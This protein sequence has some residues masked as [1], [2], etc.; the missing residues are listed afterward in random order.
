M[1]R[2]LSLFG[3]DARIRRVR[4]ALSEGATAAEDRAQLLG[5]A[6]EDEKGHLKRLMVLLVALIGLTIVMASLLSVAVVV[7]FWDTPHRTTAAW[8][9]AAL[10][11]VL[12]VAA[13]V[14]LMSSLR[15]ASAAME[16]ARRELERDWVYLQTR[17]GGDDE[18]KP[19]EP[20]PATRQA[21]LDRIER[22]RQRLM[23]EERMEAAAEAAAAQEAAAYEPPTDKA[24]RLAR[25]HPIAT[26]AAAAVVMAVVGPRHLLKVTGWLVPI[27][28]KL[29]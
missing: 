6:W 27:L 15:G 25:E 5:M 8:L 24:M 2:L 20:R 4:A 1:K 12:W 7:H 3:I 10:W 23:L 26:G 18:D 11:V 21:L 19:R 9:V 22:Q 17:F 28:W 14:G 13:L 16:P 29:R